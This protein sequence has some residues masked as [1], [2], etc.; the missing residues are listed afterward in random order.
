[1]LSV[2]WSVAFFEVGKTGKVVGIDHIQALVDDAR[3]NIKKRHD[4][5]FTDRRIILVKGDGREGYKEE[6]PYNAI[7]VGA[8]APE[9]PTQVNSEF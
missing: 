7:H 2:S 1:M 5:L 9:I 8:A 3:R 6:A 4:D